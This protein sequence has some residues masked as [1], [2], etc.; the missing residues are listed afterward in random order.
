MPE[1][2]DSAIDG[3]LRAFFAEARA[4][5]GQYGGHYAALW[6]SI[7]QQSSGGKRVRPRLV[8]SAYRGFGGDDRALV[9]RVALAFELLHTA[10]LIHDDLIDRD[11]VRRG[12]PNVAGRF[13]ARAI[14][15][16]LPERSD[17]NP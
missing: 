1:L 12:A 10:F 6:E 16:A 17:E 2:L 8:W 9:T 11:T 7:E 15:Y 3:G 13:A 14:E 4:R 5:A